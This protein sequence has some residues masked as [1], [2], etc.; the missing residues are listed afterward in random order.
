MAAEAKRLMK[1]PYYYASMLVREGIAGGSVSG[2][3][4]NYAD[5]VKPIIEIIG[6]TKWKVAAG[7]IIIL[8]RDR[9]LFLAD[10]TVNINPTAEQVATTAINA[11]RVAKYFNIEPRVAMLSYSNF[12]GKKESPA[13]MRQ[14]AEIVRQID[15]DLIVDGEMQADTAISPGITERIFPFSKI[16][17]G[18]NILV[19]PELNSGNIGYKLIQQLSECQVMGP[20]LLGINKP[21]NVLQRTCKVQDI[22]NSIVLTAVA[23][24]A[25]TKETKKK[26]VRKK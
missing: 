24:Q 7:L 6:A 14:A 11:A 19:F 3:V 9:L 16:K 20:F 15:P 23:T 21:A 10:T 18:A 12:T 5:C 2:A 8:F 17:N 22:I 25:W 1:N 13:K 26:N 4:Q